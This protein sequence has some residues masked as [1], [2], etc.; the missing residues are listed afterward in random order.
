[1]NYEII[2]IRAYLRFYS[3]ESAKIPL[4]CADC[5]ADLR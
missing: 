5:C 1:M 4:I 2:N 3:R